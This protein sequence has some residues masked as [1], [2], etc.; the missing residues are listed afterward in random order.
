MPAPP[1][2]YDPPSA[3]SFAVPID[4]EFNPRA[5]TQASW[6]PRVP[7]TKKQEG[8]LIDFNKHPDSYGVPCQA[9]L[10]VKPLHP[11]T[12]A[13][14]QQAGWAQLSLRACTLLGALGLLFCAISINKT[15]STIGWVIRVAPAVALIHAIYAIYHLS[16]LATAA[17]SLTR[18]PAS[19]ASYMI[20]AAVVDASLIPFLVFS[21]YVSYL[22][23][24]YN[25]LGWNTL[26]N[27]ET[28]TNKIIMAFFLL[29]TTLAVILIVCIFLDGY[30]A[31]V[32]RKISRLPPDLRA[33]FGL[34]TPENESTCPERHYP[35]SFE[36]V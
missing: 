33:D 2:M 25:Q 30:L 16:R 36:S 21:A 34:P 19:V 29:N 15:N 4:R 10:N 12:V 22:D 32:F 20:F 28:I 5:A 31:V 35:R 1:F 27:H 17:Q 8:P 11:R 18:T 7:K 3:Y 14:V 24:S 13:R 6:A 23:Y 26:F 9:N